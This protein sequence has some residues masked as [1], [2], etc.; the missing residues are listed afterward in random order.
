MIHMDSRRVLL[1]CV[2][3]AV[4]FLACGGPALVADRRLAPAPGT[5]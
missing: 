1:N 5:G 2:G 3:I 4:L